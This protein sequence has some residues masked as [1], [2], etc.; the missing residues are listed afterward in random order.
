MKASAVIGLGFG[1]EGK[2][3]MTS[4]LVGRKMFTHNSLV[5]RFNGGHQAGHTVIR[6]DIK[7]VF[8]NFGAGTLHGGH[9]YW[10]KFCTFDPIGAQNELNKL[11]T[12]GTGYKPLLYVHPLCPVVTPFDKMWNQQ[13]AKQTGHGS[14]GVGFG[15]TIERQENHYK[16][17][18]QD[19]FYEDILR[20]KLRSIA[21]YYAK[22]EADMA[23]FS[24][25]IIETFI[26]DVDAIMKGNADKILVRTPPVGKYNNIVF[27]G[28]QGILLDQ[29]FGFFPNVTRSNTTSKNIFEIAIELD[30]YDVDIYYMT[31]AYQ[32]RHGNGFMSG[33]SHGH[34]LNLKNTEGETNV[35][36]LYQGEFRKAPLDL[37]LI[38]YA[39]Q[40]DN[41]FSKHV[42]TKNIV[43]TCMDQVNENDIVVNE[44]GDHNRLTLHSA[45][46]LFSQSLFRPYRI[47]T[48]SDPMG[49]T[50]TTH[51]NKVE[52][53]TSR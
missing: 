42:R 49:R 18:A 10:S 13:Q 43:F 29:D 11:N 8:S 15:S 2:G 9:T 38:K 3:L 40:C 20:A 6:G 48:N 7:H 44:D 33:E 21:H 14:V 23:D 28:A 39:L 22:K 50:F 30:V 46:T 34:M 41:Y 51:K 16:L 37:N 17:F 47:M 5:V 24:N 26:N 53:A 25:K 19:L 4:L 1:D 52:Y 32:T 36:N 27:E 45:D 31:R 35:N 12:Y